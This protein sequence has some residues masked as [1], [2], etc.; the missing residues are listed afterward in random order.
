LRWSKNG[1]RQEAAFS[2]KNL[3]V[4]SDPKDRDLIAARSCGFL[5]ILLWVGWLI[6]LYQLLRDVCNG[7]REIHQMLL[8]I[9]GKVIKGST[10]SVPKSKPF[11]RAKIS[12]KAYILG[13]HFRTEVIGYLFSKLSVKA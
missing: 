2:L 12:K 1:P 7:D 10:L 11:Q 8:S 3:C 5:H 6:S 9:L 4:V 13:L